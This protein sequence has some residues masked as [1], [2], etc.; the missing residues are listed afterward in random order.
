VKVWS[1]TRTCPT[2]FPRPVTELQTI[3]HRLS[4]GEVSCRISFIE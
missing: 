1:G 4:L 2:D 3:G